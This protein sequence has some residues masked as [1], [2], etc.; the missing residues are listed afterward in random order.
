MC[1]AS[2]VAQSEESSWKA[3]ETV[4]LGGTGLSGAQSRSSIEV[5]SKV[6]RLGAKVEGR[7]SEGRR[8]SEGE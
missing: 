7:L 5:R 6:E 8:R 2:W 3:A 4:V 1:L